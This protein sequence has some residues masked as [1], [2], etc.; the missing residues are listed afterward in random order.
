MDADDGIRAARQ[1]LDAA[2]ANYEPFQV[3]RP[4]VSGKYASKPF[5]SG[6]EGWTDRAIKQELDKALDSGSDYFSW[7][8]G[9]AHVERYDL[10]RHIGKIEYNP[11]DGSFLAYDPKGKMVV[12]ESI[13]DPSELDEYVGKELGDKIRAEEASRRADIYDAM[14]SVK[15]EN[16]EWDVFMN[17]EQMYGYGGE[18][19]TFAS[20]GDA[21]DFINE[22][23]ANDF[24]SNPVKLEGL[25]IKTG[26]E[27]MIGYYDKI[28]LKRVQ[29]VLK[30][31]TGTKPEI[32]VIEV[33]TSAGPRK[34]L[35]VRLTDEMREKA[36]FSDF[37]R[38][39]TVTSPKVHDTNHETVNRALA[40]TREY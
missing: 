38:G 18:P 32:E 36:R 16:G 23:L 2:V 5:V 33:Q 4:P 27:G 14:E 30:R 19:A 15:N 29:E 28:Y 11:D 31:A 7:T 8:P 10:S 35:G 25:D 20:R 13:N 34:Q 1:R 22:Q 9:E 24:A 3:N 6:T 17:G 39:G 40:L 26:G 21:R 12:N 37:N